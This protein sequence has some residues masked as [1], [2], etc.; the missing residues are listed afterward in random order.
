MSHSKIT[1]GRS[2]NYKGTLRKLV[3]MPTL[4]RGDL[5]LYIL[6]NK[7]INFTYIHL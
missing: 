3:L 6:H 7:I 4:A 2:L 1:Q 5:A